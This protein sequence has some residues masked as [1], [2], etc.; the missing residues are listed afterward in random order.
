MT[1]YCLRFVKI[2]TIYRLNHNKSMD[3]KPPLSKQKSLFLDF[4][5]EVKEE[6][7]IYMPESN[8]MIEY[9]CPSCYIPFNTDIEL[10]QHI[11]LTNCFLEKLEKQKESHRLEIESIKIEHLLQIKYLE[12]KSE[13]EKNCQ[14]LEIDSIKTEH[15][16]QIKYLEDKIEWFRSIFQ[17]MMEFL[18]SL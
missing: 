7:K 1:W 11:I 10:S 13:R 8:D 14:Q 15:F 6:E 2:Y 18:Q 17:K 9:D 12:D 4:L 16:L 5:D 3:K